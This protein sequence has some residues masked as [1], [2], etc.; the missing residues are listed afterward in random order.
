MTDPDAT[1]TLDADGSPGATPAETLLVGRYRLGD[2]LGRGGSGVVLAADDLLTGDRVAVKF[3]PVLSAG[4]RRQLRRELTALLALRLPGV[5]RLRDEGTLGDRSFVVTN[6]VDGLPF[7]EGAVSGWASWRPR[8]VGLLDVLARVHLAGVVHRDLKPANVLVERDDRVVILD[9]GLAQGRLVERSTGG[10]VEGTP[11]YMAPEQRAGLPSDERSDLYA[12]GAMV[13]ELVTREA[14]T[15]PIPFDRLR[16]AP[17]PPVLV[18]LVERMLADDPGDRPA[19][20]LEVLEELGADPRADLGALMPAGPWSKQQLEQLFVDRPKSFV[21][22]A[23]DAAEL[24][25]EEAGGDEV[26][27]KVVLDRWIRAGLATW[28]GDGRAAI[29]RSAIEQIAA[30][31]PGSPQSKLVARLDVGA[32]PDEVTAEARRIATELA[33]DGHLERALALLDA[34]ELWA[35][36]TPAEPGLVEDVV[37][38]SVSLESASAVER[39][40]HVVH[41]AQFDQDERRMLGTLLRA[42]RAAFGGQPARAL[43][44]LREV[45]ELPE[46]LDILWNAVRCHAASQISLETHERQRPR[47]RGLGSSIAATH[48][49]MARLARVRPLPTAAIR[50]G[51]RAVRAGGDDARRTT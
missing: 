9:F 6:R 46:R 40:L 25:F 24:L 43:E 20:A 36:G 16:G 48:E 4:A 17:V 21:H 11:R 38:W 33:D 22:L 10:L 39:A 51:G 14:L 3:V 50:G 23:E 41:R 30:G 35:R 37:V 27:T 2:V 13:F 47:A 29:T 32:D 42:G 8:V 34:A 26:A 5:V 49:Q 44:F 19:S 1:L 12:V 18:D 15:R 7:T 45:F 31:R 28:N